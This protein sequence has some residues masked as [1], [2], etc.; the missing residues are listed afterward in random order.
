YYVTRALAQ[1]GS[2][3]RITVLAGSRSSGETPN[4]LGSTV[5]DYCW[6]PGSMSSRQA[7]LSRLKSLRPDLV[8]FNLGASIFGKSPW[9]NVSGSLTPLFA[10]RIGFPTVVTLHELVEFADLRALNAPGGPFAQIGARLLT[11]I[12]THADVICLTMRQ[13]KSLLSTRQLE[14]TYI[15]IGAYHEPELLEES[16][17]QELLFFTTLAPFKGLELLLE[18]F[19]RLQKVYPHLKLKIAGA[20]HARFPH[21]ARELKARFERM[22]GINWLGQVPEE[23]VMTLFRESQIVV[24][25]YQASTGSS[26]VLYQAATW[27][28]SI[29]ASD[30]RE[31]RTLADEGNLQ[32]EFFKTGNTDSLSEAIQTLLNSAQKRRQQTWHNFNSVLQTCPEVTGRKYIQAFN[33]AL[34]RRNSPKRIRYPVLDPEAI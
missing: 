29:V 26:S 25:P 1:S 2:F 6:Q 21:Y 23:R 12:A 32:I 24:V 19:V 9:S 20:E 14:C 11:K 22:S 33:R 13:Y 3:S 7:I 15:P 31:I 28:R 16:N 30:L 17:S 18:S 10:R 5:I 34:E 27:G 8:W 4:H